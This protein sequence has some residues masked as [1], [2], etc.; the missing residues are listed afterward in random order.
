MKL[1][2]RYLRGTRNKGIYLR[3]TDDSFVVW[4]DADFSGNWKLDD[5]ETTNNADTA[6]SRSGYIVS[7]LGC[8]V[9]WKS[10]LQTKI[11]LSSTE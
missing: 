2:G 6:R 7:Y 1:I 10:Q 5:D 8:P 9:L 4:A 11:A 3:P